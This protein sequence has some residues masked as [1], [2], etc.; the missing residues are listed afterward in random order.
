M[1]SPEEDQIR[2]LLRR[3]ATDRWRDLHVPHGFEVEEVDGHVVANPFA[4]SFRR[5]S[6]VKA[7][8]SVPIIY[9]PEW[10]WGATRAALPASRENVVRL[11]EW[12]AALARMTPGHSIEM[13]A[14]QVAPDVAPA[15]YLPSG[16]PN[17]PPPDWSVTAVFKVR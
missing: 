8:L 4:P 12:I 17:G 15:P 3:I 14:W 10:R 7:K 16:E 5:H 9:T 13:R 2:M 1:R 6:R 11:R